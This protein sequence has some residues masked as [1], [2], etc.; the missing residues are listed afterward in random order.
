[1]IK[2]MGKYCKA[3]HL[4]DMRKYRRW[5]EN[6]KYARLEQKEID[7]EVVKEKRVLTDESIVYLQ[8]NYNVTDDIYIED[9]ILFDNVTTKWKEYCQK[10]LNFHIPEF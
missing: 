10:K 9:N 4:G 1:M 8:E 3:Y 6:S 7:G 2:V 5:K